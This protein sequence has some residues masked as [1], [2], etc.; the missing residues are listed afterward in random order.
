MNMFR[1]L[2]ISAILM[3]AWAAPLPLMPEPARVAVTGGSLS[4]GAGFR[5]G[6]EGY[7]DARLQAAVARFLTRIERQTGVPQ[8]P[9]KGVTLRVNCQGRGSEDPVLGED[10]SYR[11]EVTPAAALLKANTVT[12]ALR[13]LET[14]AQLIVPG[15]HG[16]QVPTVQIEDYPRFP[17]RGLMLDAARH[18]MPVPVVERNLDAMA[19]VKLNVFHWHLS[20]DQGFRVESKRYPKLQ[21]LGSDGNFYTQQ[22][23]RDVVEYA[24]ARG[25]RVVPE[26]DIPG[27]TQSWLAAEPELATVAGQ[28]GI[29][30]TWG[31]YEPVIDPSKE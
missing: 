24:K 31:V 7:S 16:F 26:F 6:I 21:Q 13:G 5:A 10:E 17:W 25:I 28:Y 1:A 14:F 22:Q 29:G 3:R 12:G 11:L 15:P 30:R 20:D 23:I 4:I 2:L 27:H 9:G 19:A 8:L 18:W